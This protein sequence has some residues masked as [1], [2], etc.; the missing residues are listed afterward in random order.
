MYQTG[1]ATHVAA[2]MTN[3]KLALLGSARQDGHK[4]VKEEY[5]QEKYNSSPDMKKTI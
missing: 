5:L 3:Y 4:Q 2:E 1:K